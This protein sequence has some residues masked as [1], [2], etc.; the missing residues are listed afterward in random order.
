MESKELKEGTTI[1]DTLLMKD[2]TGAESVQV[3]ISSSGKVVWVNVDG[4]CALRVCS[5]RGTI[6]IDDD[7]PR[8]AAGKRGGR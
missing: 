5:I 1:R 6:V 8:K 4:I 7:R 3:Q 2:I